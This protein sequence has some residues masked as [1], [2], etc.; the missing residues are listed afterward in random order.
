M[1]FECARVDEIEDE[2]DDELGSWL[3]CTSFSSSTSS[4]VTSSALLDALFG[5]PF[6]AALAALSLPPRLLSTAAAGLPH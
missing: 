6:G 4:I 3:I 2:E 1:P 5:R